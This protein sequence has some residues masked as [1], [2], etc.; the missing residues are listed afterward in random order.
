MSK[1]LRE[2]SGPFFGEFGGRFMPESLIAAIDELTLAYDEAN[3]P[4]ASRWTAADGLTRLP[5][6]R[7]NSYSRANGRFCACQAATPPRRLNTLLKPCRESVR[8]A[9]AAMLLR[10]L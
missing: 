10:S 5:V 4:I 1:P 8:T 7:P 3:F 2:Q 6:N 9:A